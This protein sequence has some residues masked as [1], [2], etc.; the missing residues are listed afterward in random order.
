VND[1]VDDIEHRKWAENRQK[2]VSECL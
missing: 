1:D 2:G